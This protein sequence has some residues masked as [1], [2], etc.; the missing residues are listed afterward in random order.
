M[1]LGCRLKVMWLVTVLVGLGTTAARCKDLTVCATGCDHLSIQQAVDAASAGDVILILDS[2]HTESG[3]TLD[4]DLEIAGVGTPTPILQ[5]AVAPGLASGRTVFTI[6]SAAVSVTIRDLVIRHGTD[7][8]IDSTAGGGAIYSNGTLL[9]QRVELVDNRD[10]GGTGGAVKNLGTLVIEDSVVAR[11]ATNSWGGG[12]ASSSDLTIV[13][14]L[15]EDNVANNEGGGGIYLDGSGSGLFI[16]TLIQDNQGK[17]GGGIYLDSGELTLVKTD[18]LGNVAANNGGGIFAVDGF[19]GLFECNLEQNTADLGGGIL[20]SSASVRLHGS[21][22]RTNHAVSGGGGGAYSSSSTLLLE[23]STVDGNTSTDD[24]GGLKQTSGMLTVRNSTISGNEAA[25]SGGG[26]SLGSSATATMSG[27]TMTNNSADPSGTGGANGGGL[28][29]QAG[30]SAT[31]RNSIIAGNMDA[32]SFPTERAVDCAGELVNDVS[33]HVGNLGL[34]GLSPACVVSGETPTTG[35]DLGLGPLQDNGGPTHTHAVTAGGQH[36][37][38]GDA[39]GCR[40][41]NGVILSSDQRSASRVG[42]CDR[43]AHEANGD[44][45]IFLDNFES[46]GP[47]FWLL[48]F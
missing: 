8:G 27:M 41:E 18:L 37:D 43:G 10:F 42:V 2:T 1:S 24:G 35:G 15:I 47:W 7:N 46:G 39:L 32:S 36:Q 45:P 44:L 16:D 34:T 28:F 20:L 38:A 26:L 13:R 17:A 9:L 40:D 22:L 33:V 6:E 3:M 29:V 25:S 11:N 5:G 23:G 21:S 4:K 19:A 30:G 31:A 48:F 14:S 12:I